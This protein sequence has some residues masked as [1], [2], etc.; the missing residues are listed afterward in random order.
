MFSKLR[1]I[2]KILV[3][4]IA[5]VLLTAGSV[6]GADR[7]TAQQPG[8]N[9]EDCTL[10]YAVQSGDTLS[11]V[12]ERFDTTTNTLLELNRQIASPTQ[13]F[14]GLVL[15]ISQQPDVVIPDTGA[16]PRIDILSVDAAD[17]VTIRGRNFPTNVEF[18]VLFGE[19][20]TRGIDGIRTT[21]ITSPRDGTFVATFEM[22]D[23]LQDENRVVIR[24]ES[25]TTGFFAFNTFNNEFGVAPENC[26]QFYT[27]RRGDSLQEIAQRFDT[28][29]SRLVTI[30]NIATPSLIFPGQRLCVSTE[31]VIIPPTGARATVSVLDVDVND[32]VTVRGLEFP[33]AERFN[34]FVGSADDDARRT[35]TRVTI[36]TIPAG[37]SFTRTFDIPENFK[38]VEDLAIRFESTRTDLFTFAEF[39]NSEDVDRVQFPI[40]GELNLPAIPA[41]RNSASLTEGERVNLT[42]GNAG[43][44]MPN[45]ALSGT[46]IIERYDPGVARAEGLQFTQQLMRVRATGQGGGTQDVRGLV[47]LFFDIKAQTG[48]DFDVD[49]LRIYRFDPDDNAW[50]PCDIPVPVTDDALNRLSCAI[51]EFGLY[52]MAA[53]Q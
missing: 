43:V 53:Q 13:I 14:P 5:L 12:A 4:L 2:G 48:E 30:N 47:Q 3:A 38:D 18:D 52:G 25:P 9:L 21:T 39:E 8:I 49:R 34:V 37:G 1:L 45:S 28:T 33:S 20:G 44:F 23:R 6:G 17:D 32:D 42:Q 11:E 22:P 19:A 24:L 51:Q 31:D 41:A 36:L 46:L 40:E 50:E 35:G 29:I 27:V 7:A 15:C 26:E 10:L 16:N